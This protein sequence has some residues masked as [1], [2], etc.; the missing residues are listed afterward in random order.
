MVSASKCRHLN[1]HGR[2]LIVPLQAT[3]RRPADPCNTTDDGVKCR[4]PSLSISSHDALD[5]VAVHIGETLL[6]STELIRELLVME[7]E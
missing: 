1:N 6:P 2:P 5:H 3:N 7:P 4:A